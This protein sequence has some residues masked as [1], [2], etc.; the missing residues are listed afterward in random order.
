MKR[1]TFY[2]ASLFAPLAVPMLA[3]AGLLVA[4]NFFLA[5]ALLL[6]AS[7][8]Y[9]GLPY[10]IFALLLFRWSRGRA[11]S[12]LEQAAWRWPLYLAPIVG[13]SMT[14]W[15]W[16]SLDGPLQLLWG[17][18]N[19]LLFTAVFGYGYVLLIRAFALLLTPDLKPGSPR[20]ETAGREAS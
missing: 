5:P 9:A 4:P 17:F 15:S 14:I 13:A 11:A 10:L 19:G 7:L 18:S 12:E 1:I 20:P 6:G 3:L 2:R 16:S 8:I